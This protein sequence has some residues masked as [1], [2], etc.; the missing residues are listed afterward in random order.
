MPETIHA[1]G[2]APSFL[3]ELAAMVKGR[4]NHP[5][6]IQVCVEWGVLPWHV[7]YCECGVREI[8]HCSAHQC[9]GSADAS[10]WGDGWWGAAPLH[11][12]DT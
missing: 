11:F 5:S 2:S 10:V 6:I 8:H 1:I 9:V 4:R 7:H 3:Q 12:T